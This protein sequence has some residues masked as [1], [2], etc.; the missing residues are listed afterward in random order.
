[1]CVEHAAQ[2]DH[3]ED[4]DAE[5]AEVVVDCFGEFSSREGRKPRSILAASR[6]NFGSDQEVVGIRIQ[7]L[8]NQLICDMRAIKIAGVDVIDAERN[9]FA[10]HGQCAVAILGRAEDARPCE[11]HGAIAE[12]P[13]SVVAEGEGAGP[14]DIQHV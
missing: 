4:F 7:R 3:I 10:Q 14:G 12:P 1:M 11:L 5:I 2:I 6:T 13:Y 8:V 9:G